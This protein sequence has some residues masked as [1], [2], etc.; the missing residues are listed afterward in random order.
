MNSKRKLYIILLFSLLSGVAWSQKIAGILQNKTGVA[1]GFILFSPLNSK[2]TYLIDECGRVVN[3]W[4]SNFFPGNT[5]YLLPNGNL[6]RT[7]RLEN[8][9]ISGGGGGGGVEIFGWGSNLIW[10]FELNTSVNRLHHDIAPLP[11]GNILMN[12][13]S[14]KTEAEA[15]EAGRNSALIGAERVVWS[16]RIIEV[17]P[18]PPSDFEIVWQWSLWDHLVQ[19]FDDAKQNYGVVHDHP[20]LVDVNFV[21]QGVISN[22]IH[23]NAI[24]FNAKLNQIVV[25]SPFL[26]EIWVIDHSTTTAEAALH[27]GGSSGK[28]GDL[29]YRWGNP[30]SYGAG[31]PSDRRL[32]GQHDVKWIAEGYPYAQ[33][34]ILFNNNKG[35]DYSSIE[36]ITPPLSGLNYSRPEQA[37]GPANPTYTFESTPKSS[38]HSRIMGG[39]E[40]LANGNLLICSSLQGVLVEVGAAGDTVWRYKSPVTANG[41]VGRDY[42]PTEPNFA[43]DNNFRA[44]KYPPS[45]SGFNGKDLTPQ[46][47]VEGEPWACE[48]IT[49]LTAVEEIYLNIY[50]NPANDF[51]T[52]QATSNEMLLHVVIT[53]VLGR[54]MGKSLGV[55]EITMNLSGFQPGI[56]F[57]S[58]D[59]KRYKI[60]KQ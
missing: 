17:R 42:F 57:L 21:P 20:E 23:M 45:F 59:L 49:S 47:P 1:A 56:Y 29:L 54:V 31:M 9:I 4:T 6:V 13:W 52:V 33:S 15:L 22:W 16:E 30:Q 18:I 3:E 8:N 40:M 39:V 48:T 36:I 7:K 44:K 10:S 34:F 14:I 50:P 38:L 24:D 28:G 26:N 53:D 27:S 5:S 19:D 46:E 2:Q 41:I 51:I 43:S 35:T 12:V 58:D 60:V 55:G 37:Y 25:S 11:N 32:F